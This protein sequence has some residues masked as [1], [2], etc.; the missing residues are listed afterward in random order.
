MMPVFAGSRY[1]HF[2]LPLPRLRA[3]RPVVTIFAVNVLR[4][5]SEIIEML[6]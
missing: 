3:S 5:A 2:F 4:S 6:S 1:R